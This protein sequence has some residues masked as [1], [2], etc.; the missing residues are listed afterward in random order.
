MAGCTAAEMQAFTVGLS[1]AL[2]EYAYQNAA[3]PTYCD[4]GYRLELGYDAYNNPVRFCV[5]AGPY[6]EHVAP[7]YLDLKDS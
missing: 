3:G 2:D 5:T 4:P 1:A 6:Y 7:D